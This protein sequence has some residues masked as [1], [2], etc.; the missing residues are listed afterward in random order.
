MNGFE[1]LA[2]LR[3]EPATASIPVIISTSRVLTDSERRLLKDKVIAVVN[4]ESFAEGN[5]A[6]LRRSLGEAGM[7][8][9]RQ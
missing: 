8:A 6:D 1:V 9:A 5:S 4:K 2:L 7:A 3:A